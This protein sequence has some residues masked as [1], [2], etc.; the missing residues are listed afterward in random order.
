MKEMGQK[1]TVNW[2]PRT[3]NREADSLANG[4]ISGFDPAL[5]VVFRKD[6]LQWRVLPEALEMAQQAEAAVAEVKRKG[7]L[8]DRTKKQAKRRLE[9]RIRVTD[10]W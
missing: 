9:Q 7:D 5:E 3:A 4:E 10:P 8:P 1:A 6:R 2:T